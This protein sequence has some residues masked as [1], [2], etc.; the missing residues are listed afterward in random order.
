MIVNCPFC[1]LDTAG[2]HET[3]C[4]NNIKNASLIVRDGLGYIKRVNHYTSDIE[5]AGMGMEDK[6][7]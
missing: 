5:L 4:P 7:I 1:S 2:N 6:V 3:D